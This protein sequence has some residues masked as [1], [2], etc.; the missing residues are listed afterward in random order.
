MGRGEI[1]I[2]P[3]SEMFVLSGGL[4]VNDFLQGGSLP[5][6][7]EM[8]E[9]V[10]LRHAAR[11]GCH[12]PQSMWVPSPVALG[13]PSLQGKREG[14]SAAVQGVLP[15]PA[16]PSHLEGLGGIGTEGPSWLGRSSL[17]A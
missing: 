14:G 10:E 6:M 2:P 13:V 17:G 8:A 1:S 7:R 16:S 12:R 15:L 3:A 5:G 9:H 11:A 4:A